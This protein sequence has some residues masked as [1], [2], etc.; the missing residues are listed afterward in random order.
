MKI[1]FI[2]I[3]IFGFFDGS[4]DLKDYFLVM[5][6]FVISALAWKG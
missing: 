3:S 4:L 1:I 5:V 2:L 6:A